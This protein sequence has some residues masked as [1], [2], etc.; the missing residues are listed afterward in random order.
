MTGE[1]EVCGATELL[2]GEMIFLIVSVTLCAYI[3]KRL[4]IMKD[5]NLVTDDQSAFTK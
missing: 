3:L 1:T 5:K 2:F 4:K